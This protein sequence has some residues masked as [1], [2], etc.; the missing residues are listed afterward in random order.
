MKWTAFCD[1][2]G[3][4]ADM[5]RAVDAVYLAFSKAF[6][7]FSHSIFRAILM[8]YRLDN[9]V[10]NWLDFWDQ[11]STIWNQKINSQSPAVV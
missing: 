10:E 1:E 9:W 4:F 5:G 8:K 3:D 6:G 7:M 2:T 11:T